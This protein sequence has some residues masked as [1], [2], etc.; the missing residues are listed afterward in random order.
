MSQA[1]LLL[2]ILMFDVEFLQ[3]PRHQLHTAPPKPYLKRNWTTT[4]VHVVQFAH[5]F[6]LVET[7]DASAH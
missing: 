6:A 1:G 5:I 7:A 4:S 2:P 3:I